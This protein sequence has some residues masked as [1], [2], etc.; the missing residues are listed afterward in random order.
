MQNTKM[1]IRE[2]TKEDIPACADI[3][4]SVYNNECGCAAGKRIP[5]LHIYLISTIPESLSATSLSRF[6]F[7]ELLIFKNLH[8]FLQIDIIGLSKASLMDIK[9]V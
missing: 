6:F 9:N 4:C 7:F 3:M 5:Q 8:I 2:M 1:I